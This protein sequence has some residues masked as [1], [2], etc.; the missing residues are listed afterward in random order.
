MNGKIRTP[1]FRGL[2]P[3]RRSVLKHPKKRPSQIYL[4]K[5]EEERQV[6]C[7]SL[8]QSAHREHETREFIT[9][10][11]ETRYH[12]QLDLQINK[13]EFL[14][15]V[16]WIEF[17]LVGN[18]WMELGNQSHQNEEDTRHGPEGDLF[19]RVP[20]EYRATKVHGHDDEGGAHHKYGDTKPIYLLE[21][22]HQ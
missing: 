8:Y 16:R 1:A 22:S 20:S 2:S 18:K 14:D 10:K 15:E 6:V 9:Y 13:L 19:A 12:E 17:V 21:L 4:C 3:C 5:L 7:Q 11:H